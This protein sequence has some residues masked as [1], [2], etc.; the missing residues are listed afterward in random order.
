MNQ[1]DSL[2]SYIKASPT[3]P[4]AADETCRRLIAAGYTCLQ[5]S[6]KWDIKAGGK[7]FVK[8]G[9]T[10]VAAFRIPGGTPAGVMAVAAHGDS[11]TFSVTP[12]GTTRVGDYVRLTVEK[13]G[14][15]LMSTWMDRPLSLAGIIGVRTEE[16]IE[17]RSVVVD[18]DL[19]IIP[20]VAIHMNRNANENATYNPA[21]DMQP[22]L[23]TEDVCL[24]EI[25]S[26]AAGVKK[27]DIISRQVWLY[28]RAE[29]T[30]LGARGE[31]IAAPRLDDLGCACAALDAFLGAKESTAM[32]MYLLFDNE[33]IGSATMTGADSDFFSGTVERIA[34]ALDM[35]E[36]EKRMMLA[37]SFLVSA[38]NAHARH[39]NHPEYA[40]AKN[41]PRMNGGVVIKYN[42]NCRYAT[43]ALSA[44]VFGEICR[45]A[46][47]PVQ[48]YTNRPDMAGG[49]T[50][51][52]ISITH[53]SI[54]CVDIGMA[55][56]AMHASYET[57][58]AADYDYMVKA[59]AEFYGSALIVEQDGKYRIH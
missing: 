2:F 26:E 36:E 21:V 53:L 55:Q 24:D 22:L 11:P 4:Q 29:P 44:A 10:A 30:I 34:A 28:L 45:R 5:E 56:L 14:G 12:S 35:S 58:G 54:P 47:V 19:V 18:R 41:A 1:L 46:D 27:E 59:L 52:C 42:A 32:P 25:L 39:P 20:S 43:D 15:M 40:D 3:A 31:F 49:S 38:D 57:A 7:Y 48:T 13:Y 8:R 50:L 51:G 17:M 33:E 37:G 9:M 6:C 23:S 16:G